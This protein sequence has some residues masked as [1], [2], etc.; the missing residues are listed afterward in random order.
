M[1][2]LTHP[3]VSARWIAEI[4]RIVEAALAEPDAGSVERI[5]ADL[6]SMAVH[7]DCPLPADFYDEADLPNYRRHLLFGDDDSAYSCLLIKWP[8]DHVT[9]LHDHGGVWGIELVIDG[10]LQ[11]D[12]FVA[13]DLAGAP[14]RLTPQRSLILGVCDSTAFT[15]PRYVHR[16]RNLSSRKASLSLHVYGG[17]LAEFST[18]RPATPGRFLP[19]R[20]QA[21]LDSVVMMPAI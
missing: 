12:E 4:R 19:E 14:T 1:S 20:Q 17:M 3:K 21:S 6:T 16:C 18:F 11:V 5:R 9:P 2:Q 10:A 15:D 8:P 13:A 7:E